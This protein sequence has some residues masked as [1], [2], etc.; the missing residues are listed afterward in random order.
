MRIAELVM[1][2]ALAALSLYVMWK[3]GER[4]SWSGEARFSNVLFGDDGAPA[5]GFWP[6]WVALIMFLCCIWVFV[7]GVLRRSPPSRSTEPFLDRHGVGVLLTVGIPVFLMVLLTGYIS[8][9]FAVA[10]F[11]F[12]YLF[13]LGRHGVLLSTSMAVV[14]PFWLY[15]F[16]DITMQ[17]NM[18][19]GLRDLEY[20]VWVPAGNW[21]RQMDGMTIAL[22]FLGGGIVLVA[23][24]VLSSRRTE[25]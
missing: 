14:M 3:S 8:I 6:F 23:A 4:P 12:Y 20:A 9:Y 1:A 11:L 22:M 21:F 5:G 18:P 24:S 16:F 2:M 17:R 7:N 25:G 15:L 13:F 19:K 10:L